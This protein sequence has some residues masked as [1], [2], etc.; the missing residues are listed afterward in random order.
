MALSKIGTNQLDST[1]TP[2]FAEL[3]V[4]NVKVNGNTISSTDTNGDIT[5]DPD[6][7]GAV[8]ITGGFT[9]TDGCTITTADNTA[10]LTLKSTDA[11]AS[12]GPVLMLNRDSGSPADGDVIGT[13][14]FNADDDAGNSTLFATIIGK[15]EDASNGSE[16]GELRIEMIKAGADVGRLNMTGAETVFNEDSKD[17]DFRVE[18]DAKTAALF[19]KGGSGTDGFL[20]LNTDNPQKMLHLVKNDSDGIMIFDADGSTTDHQICFSKDYGTGGAT[21]GNYWGI[22]VD[23]SENKLVFAYDPNAQASLSSDAKVVLNSSGN[24]LVGGTGA[25]IN[26]DS[27][28][29]V[30]G[31]I[32]ASASGTTPLS[33]NRSGSDGCHY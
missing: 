8:A 13:L 4:D 3:D 9:A 20:G 2:T 19:V 23:G 26:S 7:T 12:A 11:D 1:A 15:V 18:S 6:G 33:L 17:I 5:I 10:Q 32:D 21:G 16:D 22:G 30:H 27:K 29:G 28:L 24:L 25:V 31:R 14:R